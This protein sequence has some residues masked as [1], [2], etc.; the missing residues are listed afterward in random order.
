M[1]PEHASHEVMGNTELPPLIGE[2][3]LSHPHFVEYT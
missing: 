1:L 2:P 3:G